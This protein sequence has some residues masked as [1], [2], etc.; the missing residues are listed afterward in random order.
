MFPAPV[1]LAC[2]L[3]CSASLL[4]AQHADGAD[5]SSGQKL[6]QKL[7]TACHGEN[8]KGGRGPDLTSGEWRWG[9]ADDAILRNIV[10]G[11]PGTEMPA[12]P[13]TASEGASMVAYLH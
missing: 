11:I 2:W 5:V 10:Q 8:A 12:F 4:S 1:R 6:F 7:C 13:V 3:I 9:S